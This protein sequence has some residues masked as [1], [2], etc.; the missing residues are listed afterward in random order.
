M[1]VG[2]VGTE[3]RIGAGGEVFCLMRFL[4][5]IE[6]YRCRHP[7]AAMRPYSRRG[8]IQESADILGNRF[9]SFKLEKSIFIS[10]NWL[11]V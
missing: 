9:V 5:S 3:C 6:H 1:R 2:G 10:N 7:T 4:A 11:V 8:S